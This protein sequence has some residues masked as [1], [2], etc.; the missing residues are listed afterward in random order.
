M[1]DE[2]ERA[3]DAL[4]RLTA[5]AIRTND[6]RALNA[7]ITTQSVFKALK[8]IRSPQLPDMCTAIFRCY[9]SVSYQLS[10]DSPK[11]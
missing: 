8:D 11:K 7:A 9:I 6:Q 10:V 5:I 2:T 4:N 1:E 3:Q